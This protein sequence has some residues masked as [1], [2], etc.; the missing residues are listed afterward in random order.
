MK[1]FTSVLDPQIHGG[2]NSYCHGPGCWQMNPDDL[3]CTNC[4]DK[5][6]EDIKEKL[7]DF[8][9]TLQDLLDTRSAGV[10]WLREPL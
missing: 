8:D 5:L 9:H 7:V 6:P 3:F 1:H 2:R 10:A 4:M